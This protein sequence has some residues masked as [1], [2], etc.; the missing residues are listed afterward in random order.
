MYKWLIFTHKVYK[1]YDNLFLHEY[2]GQLNKV[3]TIIRGKYILETITD[4]KRN[5]TKDNN[6]KRRATFR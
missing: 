1:S 4:I 3:W 6:K 2:H 5:L